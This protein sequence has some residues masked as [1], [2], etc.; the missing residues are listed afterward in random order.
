VRHLKRRR[1]PPLRT[2]IDEHTSE[3]YELYRIIELERR[4]HAARACIKTVHMRA[5]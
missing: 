4:A 5:L 3:T 1:R 2:G